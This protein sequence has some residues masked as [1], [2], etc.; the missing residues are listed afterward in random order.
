MS[1]LVRQ[2]AGLYKRWP[3]LYYYAIGKITLDP[4]YPAVAKALGKSTLPLLDL[5][6]GMGLLAA[7]LRASGHC[8]P[9]VGWDLDEE[10]IEIAKAVLSGSQGELSRR[11]CDQLFRALRECRHARCA[12]LF[13]R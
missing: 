4:A 1:S 11:E 8:A 10:K 12:A 3:R 9:L 5:G 7:Y 6:C 13:Q 2:A